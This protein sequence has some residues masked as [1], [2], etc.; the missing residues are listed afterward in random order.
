MDDNKFK[1]KYKDIKK[2]IE[3]I[4]PAGWGAKDE[5]DDVIFQIIKN[6]PQVTDQKVL[7]ENLITLLS[8]QFGLEK[9]DIKDSCSQISKNILSIYPK[10]I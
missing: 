3:D 7:T 5:Y 2:I 6:N 10:G 8:E 4:D 1:T 9:A